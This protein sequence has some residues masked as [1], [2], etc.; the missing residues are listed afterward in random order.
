MSDDFLGYAG[1]HALVVGGATGMGAAAAKAAR[2]HGARVTVMDVARPDHAADA[3]LPVDLR[4]RASVD[5]AIARVAAPVHSLFACAGVADGAA[6]LMLVNFIAQ[7]HLVER[8]I[9]GGALG[10]GASVV[11]ISSLA[12][13]SW[14]LNLAQVGAFLGTPDWDAAVGWIAAHPGTDNY[15]FSKQAMSAYVAR[16]AFP[17]LRRG[18]RINAIQPGP[19]DTP[20]ARANPDIWLAFGQDYRDAAG[21][22]HLTA[23]EMESAEPEVLH[24]EPELALFGGSGGLDGLWAILREGSGYLEDGGLLAFETGVGQHD[25]LK[26]KAH[27]AGF[28]RVESVQD[29]SRRERYLMLR[30]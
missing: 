17:L 7:R 23:E 20:L 1:R 11:M 12:G 6:G 8:L 22:A 18:M 28:S 5:N 27:G 19:T 29:L 3:F 4:D 15:T 30:K 25:R 16:Q 21:V 10:G 9:E 2:G 26:E 14:T 13:L 24:Y